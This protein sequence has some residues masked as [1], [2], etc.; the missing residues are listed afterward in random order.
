MKKLLF[1][2]C[3]MAAISISAQSNKLYLNI[4]SHNETTDGGAP[5]FVDYNNQT[6]YDSAK[7]R[8]IH[9]LDT[10]VNYGA[11]YNMQLESNFIL[12]CM[13]W[14]Q[15]T[16]LGDDF[17]EMM[18]NHPNVEVDP[19]NHLDLNSSNPGYNPYNYADLDSLLRS[20]GIDTAT[21]VGG[22]IYKATD[23]TY[24]ASENWPTWKTSGLTGNTFTNVNWKPRALWGGGT[25]GHVNDPFSLG[26][27]HPGSPTPAGFFANNTSNLYCVGNGCEWVIQDTTNV[28]Q[29][30][31]D[32]MEHINYFQSQIPTA[33]TFYTGTIM[34]N[35]RHI[36]KPDYLDS[37]SKM[38]RLVDA[39]ETSGAIEWKSLDEK[40]DYWE[41]VHT[42]V[43]DYFVV[44][45]AQLPIGLAEDN[46]I[47]ETDFIV[48]PNPSQ[49]EVSITIA[50]GEKCFL[51]LYNY[52]G[53][54]TWQ[55]EMQG[56][57]S[58][59][60]FNFEPITQGIYFLQ[61]ERNGVTVTKK[62]LIGD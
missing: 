22:F 16:T 11:K 54:C 7:A 41:Q 60:N 37:I 34:F 50:S 39:L 44:P 36:L 51:R 40:L 26:V 12:A 23:W 52:L 19:H 35:F 53:E 9:I 27:W 21:I 49:G 28:T 1:S 56:G 13:N 47:S 29:L 4:G 2:I 6:T 15:A 10:I 17:I 62:L 8:V 24:T 33:N 32:F 30:F 14:D 42:N 46:I 31:A 59:Q 48:S 5:N 18:E 55:G 57:I 61:I 43:N 38:I 25:A 20:C 3:T 58:K 45:C